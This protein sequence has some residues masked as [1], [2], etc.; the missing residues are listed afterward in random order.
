MPITKVIMSLMM[1]MRKVMVIILMSCDASLMLGL[2]ILPSWTAHVRPC[3]VN[4]H[5]ILHKTHLTLF[6]SVY[7]AHYIAQYTLHTIY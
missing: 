5:H 4:A 3:H 7:I 1:A 6:C 2:S